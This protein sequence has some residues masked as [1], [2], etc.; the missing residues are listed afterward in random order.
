MT[1]TTDLRPSGGYA[2]YRGRTY[3][4]VNTDGPHIRLLLPP[5]GVPGPG[6]TQDSRGE[7]SAY[8]AR[9]DLDRIFHVTTRASWR[10]HDVELT[11]LWD[12]LVRVEGWAYP[13]PAEPGVTTPENTYWEAWVSPEEL[14]EVVETVAEI[15]P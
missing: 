9:A 1:P 6:F 15:A 10:G 12:G 5:S 8:V 7:R 13:P 3:P 11:M 4:T 2:E 14:T